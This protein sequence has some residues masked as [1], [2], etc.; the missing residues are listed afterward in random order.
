MAKTVLRNHPKNEDWVELVS[1]DP[2]L[3]DVGISKLDLIDCAVSVFPW[4][5]QLMEKHKQ[6]LG[7]DAMTMGDFDRMAHILN[8]IVQE[9]RKVSEAEV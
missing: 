2:S 3:P 5:A 7:L 1:T 8:V 4:L 9:L 6:E